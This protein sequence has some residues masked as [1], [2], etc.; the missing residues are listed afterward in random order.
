LGYALYFGFGWLLYLKRE[1]VP[2]F[3]QFAWTHIVIGLALFF[4]AG[5]ALTLLGRG[6]LTR[7]ML[8]LATT[9]TGAMVVW[10][11]FFGLTGLFLRH[12][13]R[14]TPVIRYVVDSSFWIYLI[15]LPLTIWLPGL[16]SS[17][18]LPPWIKIVM[19]LSVT[20]L[21]GVATYDLFVRST[22]VGYVLNGRRYPRAFFGTSR[23]VPA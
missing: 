15:H 3:E 1:H 2:R 17:L 8:L 19:V 14:P 16:F 20:Y 22:I 10:A 4:L 7:P 21:V 23:S 12:F 5:P 11:L 13:N 18:A 6:P 9:I